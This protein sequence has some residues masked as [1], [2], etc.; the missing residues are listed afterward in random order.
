MNARQEAAGAAL[1]VAESDWKGKVFSAGWRKDRGGARAVIEPATGRARTEVGFADAEDVSEA[2]R[3]ASAA[4]PAW[5]AT[6]AE[7]RAAVL[8][9]A[10]LLLEASADALRPWIVRE[11]GSIPPKA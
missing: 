10:A 9:R 7:Q 11:T 6:P 3:A 8:R 5:A 4:Q 1:A 2:V